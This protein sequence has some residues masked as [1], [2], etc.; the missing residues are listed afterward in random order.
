MIEGH[1]PF[2]QGRSDREPRATWQYAPDGVYCGGTVD[3]VA[4]LTAK[5]AYVAM[6]NFRFSMPT[7]IL[8]GK[9]SEQEVGAETKKIG[10]RVLLHFGSDRIKTFGLYERVVRS[11]ERAGVAYEPLGGVLPNPRLGLVR[12]GIR[13]CREKKLDAILAVG[14]G[15]VIDSAKA[16]GVGVPY[17]G[18]VWD[19]FTAKGSPTATLP[20]G[21]LLT[22]PAAGSE[23]SK[24]SVITREEDSNKR[25]LDIDLIKPRFAIM[26][27]ELTCTLPPYQTAAGAADI[28]SHIIERYFTNVDHVDLTDRLCE[29]T[30]ATLIHNVPIALA[31][32]N[33]YHARAEIMWAG[34]IAHNDLLSTG[35]VGDWATHM[36]E[37]ELSAFYDVT[38]GAGLAVVFPAWMRFTLKHDLRRFVQFAVRVWGVEEDFAEP[39]RTALEGIARLSSFWQSLGLPASLPGLGIGTERLEQM[40][41]RAVSFG[42]VGNFVTIREREA[43]E[44]L[45][46]AS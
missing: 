28:M 31:E 43:L 35:R 22:I 15:S 16:I 4:E 20:V 42:P 8:F 1:A 46:L 40:A 23:A 45:K 33:N 25:P 29:A 37:H 39:E 36:I 3:P 7:E 41:K 44:I 11:L 6:E 27:P 18:D 9:G 13:L 5:G 26:N 32:P 2:F 10:S 12:E 24:S 21:V 30:L 17:S 34:T 38:H 14:G 19:F